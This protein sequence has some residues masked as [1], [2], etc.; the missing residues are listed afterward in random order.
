PPRLA[1]QPA[2]DLVEPVAHGVL[3]AEGRRPPGEDEEGRLKSVLGVLL[4]TQHPPAHRQDPRP[5]PPDE[6]GERTLVAEAPAALE[7]TVIGGRLRLVPSRRAEPPQHR[8]ELVAAHRS[9]PVGLSRSGRIMAAR[10]ADRHFFVLLGCDSAGWAQ[11]P[12]GFLRQVVSCFLHLSSFPRLTLAQARF[13]PPH[14]MQSGS[15]CCALR[16]H[17]PRYPYNTSGP[18]CPIHDSPPPWAVDQGPE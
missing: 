8:V 2:G 7:Q 4:V 15:R 3:P 17:R 13:G 6:G 14:R 10:A 1:G 18:T 5:V 9:A 16:S 12:T 11:W